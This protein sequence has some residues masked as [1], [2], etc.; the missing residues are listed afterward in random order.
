MVHTALC[1]LVRPVDPSLILQ[2][3]VNAVQH[4]L[5]LGHFQ[6]LF[7]LFDRAEAAGQQDHLENAPKDQ[8]GD[9]QGLVDA[10]L[11]TVC[12]IWE[13]KRLKVTI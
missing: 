1:I 7:V 6:V 3:L 13:R 2:P 8:D 10:D 11:F 4:T 9:Q 12:V 5:V